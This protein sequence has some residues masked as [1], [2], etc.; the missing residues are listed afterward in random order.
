MQ[1]RLQ[2]VAFSIGNKGYLGMGQGTNPLLNN[3]IW[4]Y[5]PTANN[6]TQKASYPGTGYMGMSSFVI[7]DKAYVGLGIGLNYTFPNT[8]YKF[9]PDA[10]SW[11][12]IAN[13]PGVGRR[14]AACF[15]I[16]TNGY[17]CAGDGANSLLAT[18][19]TYN[20][21]INVWNSIASTPDNLDEL[22]HFLSMA[23]VT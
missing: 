4:E 11:T 10:N 9:D 16:G 19:Y 17:V 6:W 23:K 5:N 7:G 21:S 14:D 13:F 15:S 3:D 22:L 1:G 12:S 18:C 20:S 2:P 8:F